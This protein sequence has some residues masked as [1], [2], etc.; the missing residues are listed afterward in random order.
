[1]RVDDQV[2]G[3][4]V[5]RA[6]VSRGVFL[7]II[8]AILLPSGATR[9]SGATRHVL[10]LSGYNYTF[11][12]ATK[13]MDGIQKR[14]RERAPLEIVIDAEFLD[15][16][17]VTD[18]GHALRTAN[19]VRE[20]YAGDPPDAV[21][22]VGGVT[23][24]FVMQYRDIIAPTT[25]IL[26][27]GVAPASYAA[28]R[29]PPEITGIITKLDLEK[30][31]E[32]AERLQPDAR[33]LF[34]IAGSSAVEDRRWQEAA[35]KAVMGHPRQFDTTYLF[36]LSYDEL[37]AEVSKVPRDSIVVMLTFFA[38][39]AGKPF[40]PGEVA[41]EIAR[42]SPAPVYGP[43]DTYIGNGVVGGFVE[44][45]ESLGNVA[46][47]LVLEVLA[48]KDPATIPAHTNPAQAFRVDARAMDRFGLN[49]SNL[50]PGST[51]LFKE[52]SL[53]DQHRT[54]IL[55]TAL[56]VALQSLVLAALLSQ[57]LRRRQVEVSLKESED[58]MTFTA[59]S[60]NV[61]LWQ[62]DRS[63]DELW[64]TEHCRTLFGLADDIPF[65]RE[66]FLA[67]VHPEDRSVAVGTL[68][69][70]LRERQSAVT[71]V[72]I[73]LQ[74]DR[75]RWIRVRVRSRLGRQRIPDQ[76]SGLFVDITEQ[77]A[78]ESE[79]ESRRQ[80]VTHLMRVSVLG[81]LSGAI[82]HEV[83]QPLTAILS[84]AQAALYLLEQDSPD[85]AEV[86]SALQ[87]IVQE[88]NRAGAVIRRLRGMLKKGETRFGD[89]DV[90]EMVELTVT[91]LRS[92][93]I[94]RR[95]TVE[96]DLA[97][98]LPTVYGD[99]VQL[100]QVLL[101]LIMN[102]MDAMASTPV[103]QRRIEIRTRVTPSETVEVIVRDHGPGIKPVDGNRLFEPFHTTKDHGLGLGL[104][105]CS[106]IL[107]KH[108]GTITLQN[109]K[110]GGAAAGFSLPVQRMLVAAQ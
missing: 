12:A 24:H 23:L 25:P 9:A 93:L 18:P 16:V 76:L 77:K 2:H 6:I 107:Q 73:V 53:W 63:T 17:R 104:T 13:V 97:T 105:I 36:G 37:V 84:N 26:F 14:L 51:V 67:A 101:N 103:P 69:G 70:A 47:D 52:P 106:A 28:E 3:P 21:V 19:F 15:L 65:T 27:A 43:Y 83:N 85:L 61:G 58:R 22:V 8:L 71:D 95:I 48:G 92:E 79:A 109:D 30:T 5:K 41:K 49:Q 46:A 72:R 39:G 89:V 55:A 20:K 68:R 91:L 81:E 34:V 40:V 1:V 7:L 90:N 87:D 62:F 102:A 45:F 31:I 86:R 98:N 35:R 56:V 38:D 94:G 32:L 96:T 10:I 59:A 29:P 33:R 82:A 44:T 80:E 108:G 50:P 88:D 42:I 75:V 4:D 60:V 100:Q 78:A 54:F 57:R 99:S 74:D 110:A 64:A 66:T 11:P